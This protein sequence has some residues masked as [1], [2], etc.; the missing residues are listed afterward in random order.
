[1]L[2]PVDFSGRPFHF[3]GIGGIGMSAI[4]YILAKQGFTV[5]GSDL[6]SNRITQKL[7]DLGVTVFKGHHSDNIDLANA[8]QVVCSTAINQQNPE[9]Q[10]AL[11][12]GLPI[13]H[14][15]DLLAALIEQFQG[16]S[17]AGTH[18]KTTTSSL[19]GFLLLKAGVDPSIIIGGEVSA[20]QGNARLGNGKYL[21]AEA[22]ESDG[23]LVKFL[24]H[25]GVI[26]NIELDHP[27]HYH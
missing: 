26:T 5:S 23:T 16:I 9:F 6:S 20:W 2:N 15:S 19:V 24:S 12:N 1:M 18:G 7:Q 27:D 25:I 13:L 10:V 8:P 4:A 3:V 11:A 22:D 14:R 17:I 21:V